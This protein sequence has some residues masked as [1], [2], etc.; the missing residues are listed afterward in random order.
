M[1]RISPETS[2]GEV[3]SQEV[4]QLAEQLSGADVGTMDQIKQM[5]TYLKK[6]EW[7]ELVTAFL[8]FFDKFSPKKIEEGA[9]KQDVKQQTQDQ[10]GALAGKV[11]TGRPEEGGQ[12]EAGQEDAGWEKKDAHGREREVEVDSEVPQEGS[13][14]RLEGA[15]VRP[16]G[17]RFY[18][19]ASIMEGLAG[20][21]DSF[22]G[23]GGQSSKKILEYLKTHKD[24][25][26]GQESVVI[27]G[28]GNDVKNK[29]DPEW[30]LGNMEDM[31]RICREAGVPKIS[32]A[33]RLPYG[34]NLKDPSLKARMDDFMAKIKQKWGPDSGVQVIDLYSD[35]ADPETGYAKAEYDGK[36]PVHLWGA[37][38]RDARKKI[39]E[40]LSAG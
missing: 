25:L 14:I 5:I 8:S 13:E 26:K 7:A 19:G 16:E 10:L 3:V 33:L 32:V 39:D 37:A 11:E 24:Y 28:Y 36:S 34:K 29:R 40:E 1:P 12:V 30:I 9:R 2:N 38:Y 31:I 23:K 15:I 20:S 6:G 17:R 4:S 22:I 18:I 21:K 27:Q 35:F